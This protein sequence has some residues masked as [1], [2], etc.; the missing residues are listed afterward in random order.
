MPSF[1]VKRNVAA[2]M[3]DG[4][5]LRADVY[6]PAGSG[7]FPTMLCRTPYDKASEAHVTSCE[8]FARRG[9]LVVAQDVRGRYA[10]DGEFQPGFFSSDHRDAEDGFDTVEWAAGLPESDGRVGTFGN[11]YVGWTQWELAHTRPPHLV[12]MMPQGIA[13]N[14]L[15]RELS[16]V[17]RLGRVLTWCT[18]NLSIDTR[19]R[20]GLA[21]GPRVQD[22]A[23]R[24][25]S[26]HDRSKWLWHLPLM[27]IPD[28]AMYGV[29][30]HF[31]RWLKDHAK[32]H[33]GFE[34]KHR[35]V[36]VPALITTGWYDQQIGSIKHFI[37]MK[38]NGA[39]EEARSGTRLIVGPWTHTSVGWDSALGEVD[40][41]PEATRDYHETADRWFSY[42]IKG[43][44]NGVDEWPPIQLFV[45]GAN[46]WRNES[47]WPLPQTQYTDFYL[48]GGGHANTADGDGVLSQAPPSNEPPDEYVYDPRDPVMSRYSL[49]G[50]L[51]PWDQ[52]PLDWRRDVLVYS[53]PP[54]E[55]AVEVT[56]PITATLF[57]ASTAPD[58]DFV[59][60]LVDRR[61]D[62]FAQ[63]LCHGIVR[64]RYRES[65]DNPSLI[66]PGQ[67]Y[68]Y[69]IQVNP[70]SNLFKPGHRIQVHISS[71]DFPNFDRNHNTGG[72]DYAESTLV[73]ARQ[74]I[75]HDAAHPSRITLPVIP[76]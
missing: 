50:Q 65:F 68:E 13:A 73:T 42:W 20:D 51:E 33:F 9:Y 66:K 35:D 17:L 62:G 30:K 45:M 2:I 41:G 36:E 59:V 54:L 61:P 75:F 31:R 56:G 44:R 26:G 1:R 5:V 18:N 53:T 8:E 58:T 24:E 64:A 67:V 14:L 47:E 27:E 76:G 46:R 48:R 57:A 28:H 49:Q 6:V 7:P 37:G 29:S 15:D 71:S 43:E 32:D 74:T 72:N 16:G 60:K 19:H 52:S 21:W 55:Q 12:C 34:A 69:A 23:E 38:A 70:T 22:E 4:T 10:S 3:R 11:S 39:T 25:F 40:F 63:E